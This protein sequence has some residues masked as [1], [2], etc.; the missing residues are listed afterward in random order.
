VYID[1][2]SRKKGWSLALNGSMAR[3]EQK[4]LLAIGHHGDNTNQIAVRVAQ[5]QKPIGGQRASIDGSN[6][7]T[8]FI[9]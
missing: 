2:S 6:S 5:A 7:G 8:T 3:N 4:S 1:S 9:V